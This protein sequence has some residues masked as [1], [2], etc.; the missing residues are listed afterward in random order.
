MG[1]RIRPRPYGYAE[2][3]D[4]SVGTVRSLILTLQPRPMQGGCFKISN[5]VISLLMRSLLVWSDAPLGLARGL[6]SGSAHNLTVRDTLY[7]LDK[8]R[9]PGKGV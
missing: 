8:A 3:D 9:R 2:G 7:I 4:V 5:S 1:S 6:K